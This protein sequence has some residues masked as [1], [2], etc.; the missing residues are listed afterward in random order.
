MAIIG[1]HAKTKMRPRFPILAKNKQSAIQQI[2]KAADLWKNM[3]EEIIAMAIIREI[4]T[5]LKNGR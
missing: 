2:P 1:K 5:L 4:N 3:D